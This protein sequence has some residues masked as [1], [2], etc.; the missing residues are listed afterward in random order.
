VGKA[1]AHSSLSAMPRPS[2][3]L[4]PL[5]VAPLVLA[6]GAAHAHTPPTPTPTPPTPR[7]SHPTPPSF[8]GAEDRNGLRN[9]DELLFWDDDVTSQKSWWIHDGLGAPGGLPVGEEFVVM[10]D[11]NSDPVDGDSVHSAIGSLLPNPYVQDPMPA[12]AGAANRLRCRR[13]EHGPR[14]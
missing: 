10:G 4:T 5:A 1:V 14:R 11:L 13:S 6:G 7:P 8:D 12:S 9:A 3:L 2:V